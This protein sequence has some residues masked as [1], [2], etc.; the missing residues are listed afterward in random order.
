MAYSS[1]DKLFFHA[2]FY[3]PQIISGHNTSIGHKKMH[4]KLFQINYVN[5]GLLR[6]LEK[7]WFS[8]NKIK[9]IIIFERIVIGLRK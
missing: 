5:N 9:S 6:P 8:S 3:F 7:I 1:Y 2:K 4:E